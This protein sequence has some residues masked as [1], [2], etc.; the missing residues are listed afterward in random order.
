MSLLVLMYDWQVFA[1]VG[2]AAATYTLV[3]YV[4]SNTP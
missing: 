4:K 3:Y 1:G 2:V